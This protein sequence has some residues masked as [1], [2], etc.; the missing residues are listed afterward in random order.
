M[1]AVSAVDVRAN[2]LSDID[3]DSNW[4]PSVLK[5]D[6][7]PTSL[8]ASKGT[9]HCPKLALPSHANLP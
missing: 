3:T 8:T 2:K 9:T 1:G 4:E 7:G 6:L 5:Q